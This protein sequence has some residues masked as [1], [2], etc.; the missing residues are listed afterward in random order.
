MTPHTPAAGLA[1]GMWLRARPA[2]LASAAATLA[3]AA[4]ASTLPPF[5]HLL[6]GFGGCMAF[7]AGVVVLMGVATHGGAD[8]STPES[9]YPRHAMVFPV[10]TRTLVWPQ[11]LF[12][13]VA[14]T[15]FWLLLAPIAFFPVGTRVTFPIVW[16]AFAMGA[17]VAWLQVASWSSYPLPF[18][19]AFAALGVIGLLVGAGVAVQIYHVAEVNI[20]VLM[21]LVAAPAYP[22]AVAGLSRARRGEGGSTRRSS[23]SVSRRA[24]GRPAAPFTGPAGAILWFE[25][26][27]NVWFPAAMTAIL[28]TILLT[29][30][31]LVRPAKANVFLPQQIAPSLLPLFEVACIPLFMGTTFGGAIGKFDLWAKPFT[32]PAFLVARPISTGAIVAG[33][34]RAAAIVT[35]LVWA[36]VLL[37]LLVY[38]FVPHTYDADHSLASFLQPRLTFRLAGA[39]GLCAVLLIIHTWA[40][41]ARNL[42]VALSGRPWIINAAPSVGFLLTAAVACAGYEAY[43]HPS[44]RAALSRWAVPAIHGVAGCK[45]VVAA[46]TFGF[47]RRGGLLT[48]PRIVRVIFL[49]ST[50]AA[51]L[52]ALILPAVP[53]SRHAIPLLASGVILFLPLVRP[54]LAVLALHYNRHR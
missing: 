34:F 23:S 49:W 28:A 8:L 18:V 15:A 22:A 48:G 24:N 19:R 52:A 30:P 42:Y 39:L 12:G 31:L 3:L 50:A 36:P 17:V 45:L 11:M 40:A 43:L 47:L 4:I 46:V 35:L 5:A 21:V 29:I 14:V 44:F 16:P 10:R 27:R 32:F 6:V 53:P 51:A 1:Y 26:R 13:S 20:A 2:L 37:M 41:I 9:V 7:V 25:L 38:S 54:A 33:K